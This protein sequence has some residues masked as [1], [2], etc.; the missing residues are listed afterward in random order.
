MLALPN[1][2]S[3]DPF[4]KIICGMAIALSLGT[5]S[6]ETREVVAGPEYDRASIDKFWWGENY[7]NLW[8]TPVE[9]E[10]LDLQN[11]A[12]GLTPTFRVGGTQTRGLALTGADGRSYTFRSIN[13]NL[14]D[15]LPPEW[16]E[17]VFGDNVQDQ[18]SATHPGVVERL[19]GPR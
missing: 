17:S 14:R 7:R 11:E 8:L 19:P 1:K 9:V 16:G 18:V 4:A 15:F 2:Y 12:G 6:A 3:L 13:K 10:V 5:V